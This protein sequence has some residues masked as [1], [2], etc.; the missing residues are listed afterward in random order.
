MKTEEDTDRRDWVEVT[1][2]K[3]RCQ[4]MVRDTPTCTIV[5]KIIIIYVLLTFGLLLGSLFQ[6][7][8]N[9]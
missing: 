7:P 6:A 4:Y 5:K 1:L 2:E 3:G 9:L 8:R